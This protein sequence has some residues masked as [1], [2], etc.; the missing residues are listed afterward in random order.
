MGSSEAPLEQEAA[1]VWW[2]R[3][4]WVTQLSA[5]MGHDRH[6]STFLSH[7]TSL[8]AKGNALLNRTSD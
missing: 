3:G 2:G 5:H 1:G 7:L 4:S 6:F 8:L